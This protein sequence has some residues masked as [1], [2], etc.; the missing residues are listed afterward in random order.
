MEA[1]KVSPDTYANAIISKSFDFV[2]RLIYLAAAFI[3]FTLIFKN[4]S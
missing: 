3:I 4:V 1:A 2:K